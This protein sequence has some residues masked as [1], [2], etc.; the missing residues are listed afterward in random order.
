MCVVTAPRCATADFDERYLKVVV[1]L[2]SFVVFI[3]DLS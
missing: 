2:N 3:K 1:F